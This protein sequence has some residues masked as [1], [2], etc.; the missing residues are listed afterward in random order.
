[1][2]ELWNECLEQAASNR[3]NFADKKLH[4]DKISFGDTSFVFVQK[5]VVAI[6]TKSEIL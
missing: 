5:S 1:L 6:R 3:Q 2:C 4:G